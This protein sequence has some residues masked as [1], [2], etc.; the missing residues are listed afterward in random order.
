MSNN[1]LGIYIHVPFCKSKCPY[2]DFYSLTDDKNIENY[3][4]AVCREIDK[5]G[6]TTN[7]TVDTIYLGG[8]TPSV[9]KSDDILK[10]LNTVKDN[11]SVET[12]EITMEINPADYDKLDF[13]KLSFFG[14]NRV[15]V[16]AQSMDNK[17]L[18]VLGRRHSREDIVKSVN[19][20]KKYIKNISLDIILGAPG[21]KNEY[22]EE[23]VDFCVWN[24]VPHISAYM[25]KIEE[26][27]PYYLN[28]NNLVFFN[29]DELA[30]FYIYICDLMR[31][32]NYRHYEISNF[33]KTGFESNHNLKYWRL[34]DYLGIGP[35]AHGLI[36]GRRFYYGRDL[37]SFI[38]RPTVKYENRADMDMEREFVM[39]SLRLDTGLQN[40]QFKA[41]LG[42]D[43]PNKYFQR[44]K[45]FEKYGL[46]NCK[47][48]CIKLTEQGFLVSNTIISELI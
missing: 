16:G 40:E 35:S 2:C 14:L 41:K 7:K 10:V 5:W 24:D 26:N 27:T 37:T 39:L 17:Q 34:E 6:K 19:A 33:S 29:D 11:F 45:K 32:H 9:L 13:E 44:A 25:L 22:I 30:D 42:Y 8:G 3:V 20:I 46:I 48:D 38:Y 36:D 21:Q 15:S 47:K 43:I 23:F 4:N 31:K 1:N 18:A 28:K 12:P